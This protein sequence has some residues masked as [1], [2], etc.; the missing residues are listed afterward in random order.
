MKIFKKTKKN[1]KKYMKKNIE[2][3]KKTTIE[4]FFG[5]LNQEKNKNLF[6]LI[7]LIQFLMNLVKKEK[8][9]KK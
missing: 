8:M 1:R 2:S 6:G 4:D 9:M 3:L 7:M 5:K